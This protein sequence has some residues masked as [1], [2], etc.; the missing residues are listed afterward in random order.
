MKAYKFLAEGRLAIFSGMTWTE[1]VWVEADGPPETCR[2]GI[3]GCLPQHLAYWVLDELWEIELE[4]ELVKTPL[5]VV[6][7]RGRLRTRVTAWN[8]DA[9]RDFMAEG[10]RR[11]ARYAALELREVGLDAEADSLASADDAT[12]GD[13]AA[14]VSDAAAEAAFIAAHAA[15][16]HSPIGIEDPF[17]VE[18]ES[19]GVWLAERLGL[20][21]GG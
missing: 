4:G 13:R 15:D 8:D 6:A 21:T 11:T 17:A 7:P 20:T 12:L 18:R 2:A 14:A 5:K 1:G 3:H 10:I 19:Q 9:R 16:L